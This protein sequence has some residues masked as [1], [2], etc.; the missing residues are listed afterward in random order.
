MIKKVFKIIGILFL[1]IFISIFIFWISGS[2]VTSNLDTYIYNLPFKQ[3]TS[4][5]VVQGYGGLFSH[6]N[7]AAIDFS[8]AVGTP[9]FAAREGFIFSYKENGQKGG[10]FS[11]YK[12]EANYI[13]IKHSDGSYGC[14]WHLQYNGV[15]TKK[16]KVEKGQLIGYSGA[17]GLVVNPHLHFSVKLKL[18]Y[19][20]NSFTKTKFRTSAGVLLLERGS[21]YERPL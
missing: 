17:T 19:D 10:P 21:T 16:G 20:M 15:V 6:K 13:I 5:K 14:Y 1:L 4:H 9:I 7:I 3:G 8:M 12:N 11:T 2:K 18:N